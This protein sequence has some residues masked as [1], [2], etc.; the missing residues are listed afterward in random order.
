MPRQQTGRKV[1]KPDGADVK[2][3]DTELTVKKLARSKR[4]ALEAFEKGRVVVRAIDLVVSFLPR[5]ASQRPVGHL[6]CELGLMI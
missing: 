3:Y 5:A 4:R 2:D 6:G 1:R